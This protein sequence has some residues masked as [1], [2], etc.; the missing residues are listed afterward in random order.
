MRLCVLPSYLKARK[1]NLGKPLK[2]LHMCS[3]QSVGHRRLLSE[4]YQK[5]LKG[6]S[7]E[8]L[9]NGYNLGSSCPFSLSQ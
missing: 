8:E 3:L 1:R 6:E 7:L 2:E 4:L 5:N 9:T